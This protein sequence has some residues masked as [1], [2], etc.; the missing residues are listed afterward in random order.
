MLLSVCVSDCSLVSVSVSCF[1]LIGAIIFP[2]LDFHE[3][4]VCIISQSFAT[5][6]CGR[7]NNTDS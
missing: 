2:P 7:E 6:Y 1:L 3:S 4:L 5:K